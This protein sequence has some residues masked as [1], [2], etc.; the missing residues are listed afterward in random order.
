MARSRSRL[1]LDKPKMGPAVA[2][3]LR[4]QFGKDA[5]FDAPD[6][7]KKIALTLHPT[8]TA[9]WQQT[10]FSVRRAG[11]LNPPSTKPT[12]LKMSVERSDGAQS[13]THTNSGQMRKAGVQ[14]MVSVTISCDA[15]RLGA[16]S[17][18]PSES[19]CHAKC[20]LHASTPKD[21]A[22]T[23]QRTH[24]SFGRRG[25]RENIAYPNRMQEVVAQPLTLIWHPQC[26][27]YAATAV[28]YSSR[29]CRPRKALVF[30]PHAPTGHIHQ[31]LRP[32]PTR[33]HR[34]PTL[35]SQNR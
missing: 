5:L 12:A 13:N 29:R 4:Y 28:R 6:I 1:L 24:R 35:Q 20:S 22:T 23:D 34:A 14:V 26:A 2:D 9:H 17:V 27:F 25:R 18:P 30:R 11:T 19:F 33:H 16:R 3:P 32:Q 10:G 21:R 8:Q 7:G 31:L 15:V